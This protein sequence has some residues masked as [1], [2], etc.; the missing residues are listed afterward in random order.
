[1]IRAGVDAGALKCD[2]PAASAWRLACLLD[3]L[4]VQLT[5]H[6]RTL[7]YEAMLDQRARPRRRSCRSIAPRCPD[8]RQTRLGRCRFVTDDGP[9]IS[10]AATAAS[11][12]GT[13]M[14]A[15]PVVSATNI[16]DASGTR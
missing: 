7:T 9:I 10:W 1:M 15:R 11:K 3:G 12:P 2:D 5:L 14:L 8:R 6:T 4:G 16:T 13:T